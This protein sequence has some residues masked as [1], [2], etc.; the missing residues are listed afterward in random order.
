MNEAALSSVAARLAR[1]RQDIARAAAEAGRD[2]DSVT[3]IAVS[4]THGPELVAEAIAAGQRRFGENRV[5]E[6]A[7]KWPELKASHPDLELHLIGPLQTNKI[8]QAVALFD[9]IQTVDRDALAEKLRPEMEKAGR[10]PRCYVEVN[11]G[12]EDQK[13]GIWPGEADS[14]IARCREL[15]G[16]A[17]DGLM[18]VPPLGEPPAPHFALLRG[19]AQRH[20][21]RHLSMGMSDDFRIAI[22]Q[23]ATEVRVGTAIFGA[24]ETKEKNGSE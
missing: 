2:P 24:R 18:C 22:H 13:A 11:T 17:I 16:L 19:I 7:G 6:A 21:I 10:R 1:L 15:H 23:G 9:V 14:F 3:L 5:Q 4:K 8:R 12:E 20:G